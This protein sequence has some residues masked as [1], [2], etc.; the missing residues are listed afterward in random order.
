[1]NINL[2]FRIPMLDKEVLC[3]A[4]SISKWTA[5]HMDSGGLREWGETRRQKSLQV[6]QGKAVNRAVEIR[7]YYD[8]HP[9]ITRRELAARFDVSEKTI[10]RLK[11]FKKS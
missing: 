5:R 6:R 11:I 8:S 4:R 7:V 2:S 9:D 3:I 10:Q 1:M